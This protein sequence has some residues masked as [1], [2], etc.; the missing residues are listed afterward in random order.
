[1]FLHVL[2]CLYF[3]YRIARLHH[4]AVGFQCD[5]NTS[6][7]LSLVSSVASGANAE[8]PAGTERRLSCLLAL[9]GRLT[10][11]WGPTPALTNALWELVARRLVKS[12]PPG[13]ISV[14]QMTDTVP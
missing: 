9:C 6:Q 7:L 2:F 8:D 13:P 1:M 14:I 11:L 12:Q 4:I 5:R 10:Q 3:A